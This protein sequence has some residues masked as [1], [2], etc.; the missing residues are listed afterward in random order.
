MPTWFQLPAGFSK[1]DVEISFCY[2]LVPRTIVKVKSRSS[3]EILMEKT[4][5]VHYHPDSEK[6]GLNTNPVYS[7][8]TVNGIQEI[9]EH[10]WKGDIV[11][12][13]E[14]VATTDDARL[15]VLLK[16]LSI[17]ESKLSQIKETGDK[18][19]EL[20]SL[21]ELSL[22]ARSYDKT[23]RYA[24]ELIALA[25]TCPDYCLSPDALKKGNEILKAVDSTNK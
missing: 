7:L 19:F 2:Y 13:A 4:G 6:R 17:K 21:A 15:A 1:E 5:S 8:I 10:R 25:S 23:S 9:I 24:K 11:Y 16:E 14:E 18:F 22:A 3:G 12:V 20:E